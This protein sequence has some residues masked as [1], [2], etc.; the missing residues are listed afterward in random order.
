M[1]EVENDPKWKETDIGD[2]PMFRFFPWLRKKSMILFGSVLSVHH[3]IW[4]E[5]ARP[6]DSSRKNFHLGD[7]WEKGVKILGFF[8]QRE[9]N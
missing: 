7:C 9:T 8:S 3:L 6:H 4:K 2:T 1:M 5:T